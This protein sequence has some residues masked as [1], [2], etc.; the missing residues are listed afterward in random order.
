MLCTCL[1]SLLGAALFGGR[2][3][4]SVKGSEVKGK[5]VRWSRTTTPSLVNE[6]WV[7]IMNPRF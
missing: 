6:I 2:K 3:V 7:D 4:Q 5:S 1:F